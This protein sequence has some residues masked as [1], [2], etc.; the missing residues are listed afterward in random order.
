MTKTF[1]AKGKICILC[2]LLLVAVFSL[3]SCGSSSDKDDTKTGGNYTDEMKFDDSADISEEDGADS[4]ERTGDHEGTPYFSQQDYYNMGLTETLTILP[5]FKTIQQSS[6]WSCGVAAAEMVINYFGKLGSETE[7]TLAK[8]RPQGDT[9]SATS[10]KEE[11]AIF[12][13]VGG[14]KLT[15]TLDYKNPA[16]EIH[17]DTIENFIKEGTPVLVCWNDWGGHWQAIIG[18]DNMGTDFENDDVLIVAD[19]YD[20]TDHN[21]DGYGVIPAERFIYNFTMYDFFGKK[22][23]DNDYLFIAAK[24]E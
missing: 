19:P 2:A 10:L 4:V 12:K 14:F 3:Y 17:L 16:E 13:K 1:K 8:M 9:D 23:A 21:Q 6:E 20:T 15:T 11:I 18:Y 22:D 24:P 7:A 5:K